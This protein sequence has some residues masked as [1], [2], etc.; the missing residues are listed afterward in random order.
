MGQNWD[1]VETKTIYIVCYTN[2]SKII[3]TGIT[4]WCKNSSG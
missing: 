2:I 4:Y 3:H 1:K